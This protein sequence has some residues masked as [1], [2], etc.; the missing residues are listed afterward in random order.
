MKKK[1]FILFLCLSICFALGACSA[2]DGWI[3]DAAKEMGDSITTGEIYIDGDVFTFPMDVSDFL[4]KG[5]HLSKSYTNIE[6]YELEPYNYS[7]EFEIWKDDVYVTVS[8][9]NMSDKNATVK[10][11][12]V[13]SLKITETKADF[14]LPGGLSKRSSM[15][16]VE[17]K[18]GK[19]DKTETEKDYLEYWT[20]DFSSRDG[21][22]CQAKMEIWHD[23]KATYPLNGVTYSLKAMSSD[24]SFE[25]SI[26]SLVDSAMKTSYYDDYQEYVANLF[27]T[28]EGAHELYLSE[29][30]YYA[31][32]IMWYVDINEDYITE[33][34]IEQFR[35]IAKTVLLKAK[36]EITGLEVNEATKTGTVTLEI[37]PIIYI[38][39]IDEKVDAAIDIYN[40]KYANTDFDSMTDEEYAAAEIEYANM[41]LDAIKGIENNATSG[42]KVVKEYDVTDAGLTDDQ[43]GEIDDLIMG[44]PLE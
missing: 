13:Q 22:S 11:C 33:D 19:A 20:Y 8:A 25:E 41:V 17:D 26:R 14:V 43:W 42:S 9:M 6:T 15:S 30:D 38:E 31:S 44:I 3:D 7:T 12:M 10:D 1:V 35:D 27:D 4:D 23:G 24:V 16:D 40:T 39:Y 36:W 29:V 34:I 32:Y 2:G 18:Y 28:E 21:Y 5:W 37:Y